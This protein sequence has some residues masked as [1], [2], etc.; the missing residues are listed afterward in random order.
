M[1]HVSNVERF[2]ELAPAAGSIFSY[3]RSNPGLRR[4]MLDFEYGMID[5]PSQRAVV[6]ASC[7]RAANC[8]PAVVW[9]SALTELDGSWAI[10]HSIEYAE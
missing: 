3:M 7:A 2:M 5:R 9:I 8:N 4:I 6:K 10:S 1:E